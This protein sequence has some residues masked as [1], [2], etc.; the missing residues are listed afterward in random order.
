MAETHEA[1]RIVLVLG[2]GDELGN[3]GDGAD[4]AEHLERRFIGA[5]VRGAPQAGDAGRDAGERIGARRAGQTHRRGRGVLFVV[6]VQDEDA[7]ERARQDR[8]DLVVLAGDREAHAQEIRGVVKV[9]LRVDEGLPDR[10]LE[11]HRGERR[12]LRDHAHRGD[13]PLT[14]V[15]DVGG[16]VIKRGERAD[17]GHHHRHRVRV[18]AEALEKSRHLFMHHRVARDA[19]VEVGFLRGGRQFAVEQEIA[20]LEEIAVLG[21]LL[22]RVAAIEQHAVVAVDIGDFRFGARRRGEARIEGEHAGLAIELA[23]I[24]HR[25]PD[26]S[27]LDRQ[28]DALSPNLRLADVAVIDLLPPGMRRRMR[29]CAMQ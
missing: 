1:E 27:R 19:I 11:R 26:R 12:H 24:H 22:D 17:A 14:L 28:V 20:G 9:V 25:G 7:V 15:G 10:I 2:L 13:H 23:D 18:A 16:V 3:V 21:E 6:G 4:L 29:N 8:I 5:A